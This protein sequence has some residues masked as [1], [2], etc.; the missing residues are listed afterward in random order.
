MPFKKGPAAWRRTI[1]Y[2]N[3]GSLVFKEKVKVCSINFHE[4][5]PESEGLR[6]FLFWHLAQ[7]Q[8]KNPLVQCVQLKNIVNSPFITF[9]TLDDETKNINSIYVNCYKKSE[10]E[11]LE[12]C[13]LLVGKSDEQLEK[14]AQVNEANFGD[15]C[16]RHCICLVDSQVACPRFKPLPHFMRGKYL[17]QK[18]DEL[19]EIRKTK[20]DEQALKEYWN[21]R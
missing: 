9:H 2:L 5:R 1:N 8:Y 4:T 7:I 6:R 12:H 19:K 15:G 20:S 16:S 10:H 21:T 14:E 13:K 18:Q 17:S 11:I 3:S